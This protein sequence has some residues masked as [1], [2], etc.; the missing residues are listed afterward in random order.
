MSRSDPTLLNWTASE[1]IARTG[2]K[3]KLNSK[4]ALQ[5]TLCSKEIS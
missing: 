2:K 1:I 5:S 4:P 3:T